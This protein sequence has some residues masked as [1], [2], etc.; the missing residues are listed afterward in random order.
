MKLKASNVILLAVAGYFGYLV[1]YPWIKKKVIKSKV[2]ASVDN[3]LG[4]GDE[5]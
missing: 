3:S 4:L 1:V 5:T 2:Q